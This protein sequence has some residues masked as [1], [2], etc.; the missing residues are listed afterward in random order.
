MSQ[1]EIETKWCSDR[2]SR[3]AFNSFVRSVTDKVAHNGWSFI[4]A[5]G[6]DHYFVNSAGYVA[7]HRDSKDLKELTVKARVDK[8]D[9]TIRIERN[10]PLDLKLATTKIVHGYLRTSGYKKEITITKDCD[11]YKFNMKGSRVDATVVWYEVSCKGKA[12]R[13]FIEVEVDGG[14]KKERLRILALY[15]GQKY[16]MA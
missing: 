5:C 14:S 7:R 4:T 1:F 11:I 3:K 16:R 15:S 12:K 2:V 10:L 6:P 9:I 8:E 13:T